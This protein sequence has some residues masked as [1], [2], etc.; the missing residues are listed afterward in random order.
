MDEW[1]EYYL[2]FSVRQKKKSEKEAFKVCGVEWG[3]NCKRSL[4]GPFSSFGS[5]I[6]SE[7]K[8][9]SNLTQ[10]YSRAMSSLD[11]LLNTPQLS[12]KLINPSEAN[13][14]YT[15]NIKAAVRRHRATDLLAHS[16][17]CSNYKL[18]VN[19][20]FCIQKNHIN[21]YVIFIFYIY[22]KQT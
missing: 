20:M 9:W 8:R 19:L 4:E 11:S 21:I 17:G 18:P 16:S 13:M 15:P 12:S 10:I 22:S 5:T 2:L 14:A 7:V 6:V 1:M 3:S